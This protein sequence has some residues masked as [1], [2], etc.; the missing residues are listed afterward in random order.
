M[1]PNTNA[2]E[3]RINLFNAVCSRVNA[4]IVKTIIVNDGGT[5]S[6]EIIL[7]AFFEKISV[8]LV[9]NFNNHLVKQ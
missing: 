3:T 8:N 6:M 4:K 1:N 9:M 7:A 2:V 5:K